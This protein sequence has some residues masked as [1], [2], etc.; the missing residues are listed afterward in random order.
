MQLCSKLAA[1]LI[2]VACRQSISI[3]V[4]DIVAIQGCSLFSQLL[5]LCSLCIWLCMWMCTCWYSFVTHGCCF[6]SLAGWSDQTR[7]RLLAKQDATQDTAA[8]N[9][10]YTIPGK[11]EGTSIYF[12]A[13][14]WVIYWLLWPQKMRVMLWRQPWNTNMVC[15][16]QELFAMRC[17]NSSQQAHMGA[18]AGTAFIRTTCKLKGVPPACVML[19]MTHSS[20][21]ASTGRNSRHI[22][23]F[24][25]S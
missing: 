6:L 20:T 2:M 22:S 4:K 17:K 19:S 24:V 13:C 23:K 10:E 15:R 1:A 16:T 21:F 7:L 12:L 25:C 5:V 3:L 11:C 8:G 18:I 14:N 9:F